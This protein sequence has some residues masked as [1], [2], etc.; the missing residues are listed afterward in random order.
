MKMGSEDSCMKTVTKENEA[1]GPGDGCN[2]QEAKDNE[3]RHNTF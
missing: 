2:K 1:D 3:M